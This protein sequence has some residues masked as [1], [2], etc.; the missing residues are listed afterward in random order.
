[1]KATLVEKGKK[2]KVGYEY[3]LV[4][5]Q[6]G[7]KLNFF[8]FLIKL[9]IRASILG[10]LL[11]KKYS[12]ARV[13][14]KNPCFQ[15]SL[16]YADSKSLMSGDSIFPIGFFK[17]LFLAMAPRKFLSKARNQFFEQFYTREV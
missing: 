7:K 1:M 12:T 10:A 2:F 17:V 13:T 4:E 11:T 5:A 16:K 14:S 6:N 8:S 3:A 9:N 15:K